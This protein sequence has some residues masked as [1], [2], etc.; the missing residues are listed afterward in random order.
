MGC[1]ELGQRW[2]RIAALTL[3][4]VDHLFMRRIWPL[5]GVA[6]KGK[7]RK[8]A[9]HASQVGTVVKSPLQLGVV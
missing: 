5:A 4:H 3:G 1:G 9:R 6:R 2:L 7:R 8:F